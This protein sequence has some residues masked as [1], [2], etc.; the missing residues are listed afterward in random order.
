MLELAPAPDHV[1]AP[2]S[3]R[4][5]RSGACGDDESFGGHD[6][7]GRGGQSDQGRQ[8]SRCERSEGGENGALSSLEGRLDRA[9]PFQPG[10]MSECSEGVHCQET[11]DFVDLAGCDGLY[12]RVGTFGPPL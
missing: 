9:G 12:N 3:D 5:Q 7:S 10:G 4:A 8:C 6:A 11:A 2:L 1:H